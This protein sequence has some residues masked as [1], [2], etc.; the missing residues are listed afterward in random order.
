MTREDRKIGLS[1]ENQLQPLNVKSNR[2]CGALTPPWCRQ[3]RCQAAALA[4][5][6][7]LP[8]GKPS[9]VSEGSARR[10]PC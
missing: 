6:M 1:P 8:S 3:Q 5:T 9:R 7:V 10:I 4:K 2:P